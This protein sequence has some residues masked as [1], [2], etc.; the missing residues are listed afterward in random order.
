M[1]S[2]RDSPKRRS[3]SLV[4]LAD[5]NAPIRDLSDKSLSLEPR[6]IKRQ[7]IRDALERPLTA[8]PLT[9]AVLAGLYLVFI[10][11]FLGGVI[12]AVAFGAGF[13]LAGFSSFFWKWLITGKYFLEQSG[14]ELL[15][16][17][18]QAKEAEI[19]HQLEDKINRLKEGFYLIGSK[20][21]SKELE[22]LIEEYQQLMGCLQTLGDSEII[23]VSQIT[24]LAVS[25]FQQGLAVLASALEIMKG[26]NLADITALEAE[27]SELEKEIGR[28]QKALPQNPLIPIKEGTL[29]SHK[30]RLEKMQSQQL[31]VA[32]LLAQSDRCEAVLCQTRLDM[33]VLRIEQ[34]AEQGN[35]VID[36]LQRVILLAKQVQEELKKIE[37]IS[38]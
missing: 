17:Q 25:T 8:Y 28:L 37:G 33:N 9:V 3:S 15:S 30:E 19:A 24:Q 22:E 13:A 34:T 6:R 12:V 35:A 1:S 4:Y 26:V 36:R 16:L 32:K 21:G 10:A 2:G 29:A 20:E 23:S 11:P 7:I 31:G 18:A 27:I 14:K 5:R 38:V